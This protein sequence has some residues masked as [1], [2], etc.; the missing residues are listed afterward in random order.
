LS[1]KNQ[2]DV[3]ISSYGNLFV[4][5]DKN[6]ILFSHKSK[7]IYIPISNIEKSDIV[8]TKNKYNSIFSKYNLFIESD[9]TYYYANNKYGFPKDLEKFSIMGRKIK[10]KVIDYCYFLKT[11]EFYNPDI[12]MEQWFKTYSPRI[13]KNY[14][15]SCNI[16]PP[17]WYPRFEDGTIFPDQDERVMKL[18]SP[19]DYSSIFSIINEK[20]FSC[21]L[22]GKKDKDNIYFCVSS[23]QD[24]F[25]HN[26]CTGCAKN[27]FSFVTDELING[28]CLG[29]CSAPKGSHDQ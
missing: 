16:N 8:N 13:S 11:N 6:H 20:T 22:C 7:N 18:I 17:G 27:N 4:D 21:M 15:G 2:W 19:I 9:Y 12:K 25:D 5:G 26:F 3:F 23:F 28:D 24:I 1:F 14:P 29:R 10:N